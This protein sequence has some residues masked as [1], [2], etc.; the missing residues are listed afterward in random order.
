M[1][2]RDFYYTKLIGLLV[3]R[4]RLFRIEV[5]ILVWYI[6]VLPFD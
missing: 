1:S 3:E 2:L 5:P 6:A 4:H